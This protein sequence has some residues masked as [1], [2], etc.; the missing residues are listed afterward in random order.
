V[1][2]PPHA[3]IDIKILREYVR[4]NGSKYRAAQA[5]RGIF[6][7]PFP[8]ELKHM[9]TR[10]SLRN[11]FKTDEGYII[12]PEVIDG[13]A[14]Q[15]ALIGMWKWSDIILENNHPA[16]VPLDLFGEAYELANR[17]GGKPRGRAA[18]YEPLGWDGL[19]WC[20]NHE[21]SRHISGHSSDGTWVCDRDY[22]NGTGPICLKINHRIISE[23]LTRE[24]LKCLDLS[25]HATA[26]FD[27]V[28]NRA[29]VTDEEQARRKREEA[30]LRN[31]LANLENYLGA[32]D[33]ELEESYRRQIKQVKAQLL[34]LHQKPLPSPVT[35][36]DI[37]RV[38]HFLAG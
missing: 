6:F 10:S 19:L 14:R 18:Y 7:P 35:M 29:T 25:A 32:S 38:R 24:F 37:N 36:A 15:V 34:S 26:V 3:E 22:H 33:P 1:P 12:T 11:C 2:Y 20:L 31:R 4:C 21:T 5:L 27:E 13:L 30:Q 23:P 16:I 28:Q 17:R 9:E 8:K